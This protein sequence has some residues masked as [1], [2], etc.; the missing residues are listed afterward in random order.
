MSW[1]YSPAHDWNSINSCLLEFDIIGIVFIVINN[2][3]TEPLQCPV[4]CKAVYRH[5]SVLGY[6]EGKY[7]RI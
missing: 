6:D 5:L 3:I 4:L 7:S 1:V 2:N